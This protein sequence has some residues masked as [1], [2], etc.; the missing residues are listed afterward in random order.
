MPR[1]RDLDLEALLEEEE[2]A[3]RSEL[4]LTLQNVVPQAR[5][6]GDFD[7]YAFDDHKGEKAAVSELRDSL[8]N[9]KIVARAKVTQDR[10]YSAAY[11]P[12]VTKDLIFFGGELIKA[13]K[14]ESGFH[15]SY[16]QTRTAGHM[17][18]EGAAR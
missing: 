12:E 17:G 1:T 16:R 2:E 18:C 10:I 6:V 5:R 8:E 4:A 15:G 7:A 3:G 14:I 11:H 13:L 9:L